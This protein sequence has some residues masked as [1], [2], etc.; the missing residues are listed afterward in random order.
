MTIPPN[1]MSSEKSA[2]IV[3]GVVLV[4]Q[5]LLMLT[6]VQIL[7][8][9]IDWPASLGD[10]AAVT[11]PR[12]LTHSG[13]VMLGYSCYLLVA[14]AI[15]PATA[16]LNA[17]LRVSPAIGN[18]TMGLATL[19]AVAKTLGIGRWLLAMPQLAQAYVAPDADKAGITLI[20]NMLNDY[21]GGMGEVIGVALAS[22][23][24]T[25][26]IATMV[27]R[28]GLRGAR[29]AG[30]FA[31]LTGLSLFLSIPAWFGLDLGPILS[32]TGFSWQLSLFAIAIC[33]IVASRTKATI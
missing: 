30:G 2:F 19:S 1:P 7:S 20:F 4:V 14:L 27:F 16:A 28:S 31:I 26:V 18:L 17:A 3:G 24:W 10:P 21:A 6:T 32:I 11:L 13:S 8:R 29:L 25:L 23:L 9:A 12:L 22:G 33:L 5:F 15:I